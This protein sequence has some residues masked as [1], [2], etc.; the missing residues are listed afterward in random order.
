LRFTHAQIAFDLDEVESTL[1]AVLMQLA[2][3]AA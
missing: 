1:R 3:P 2:R